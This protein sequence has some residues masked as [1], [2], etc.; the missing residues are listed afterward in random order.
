MRAGGVERHLQSAPSMKHLALTAFCFLGCGLPPPPPSATGSVDGGVG[1]DATDGIISSGPDVDA[2]APTVDAQRRTPRRLT[3]TTSGEIEPDTSIACTDDDDDDHSENSYYRVFDLA[4]EGIDSSFHVTAVEVGV[5]A[6]DSG[7]DGAQTIEVSIHALE[8][9]IEDG[10][11]EP[12]GTATEEVEDQVGGRVTVD[13][14]A[15]VPGGTRFAVEV[16]TPDGTQQGHSFFIG[17]NDDGQS[18]PGYIRAPECDT[19]RPREL[20][21]LGFSEIAMIIDVVGE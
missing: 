4:A 6:A 5:E 2:A 15:V 10:Q 16:R 21:D 14:D 20:G 18:A 1:P 19:D 13:V 11:L 9:D 17:A 3:Q 8:G 7:G 12:L